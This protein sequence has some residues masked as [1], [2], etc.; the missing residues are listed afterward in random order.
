MSK[1]ENTGVENREKS[2]VNKF[3]PD[4]KILVVIKKKL[5]Q[6]VGWNDIR[7]IGTRKMTFGA[8]SPWKLCSLLIFTLPVAQLPED[9]CQYFLDN[10]FVWLSLTKIYLKHA[11]FLPLKAHWKYFVSF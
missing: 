1:P 6:V 7:E 2:S 3:S 10:I 8:L 11:R 9:L 4:Y 5:V